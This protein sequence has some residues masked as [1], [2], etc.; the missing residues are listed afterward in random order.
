MFLNT[1]GSISFPG[2]YQSV[3]RLGCM[4]TVWAGE[5]TKI[6][7]SNILCMKNLQSIISSFLTIFMCPLKEVGFRIC[8]ELILS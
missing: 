6:V 5:N 4:V 7:F 2:F 1:Q 8:L 3:V